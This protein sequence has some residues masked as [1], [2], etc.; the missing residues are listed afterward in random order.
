MLLGIKR[1]VVTAVL[2]VPAG[3]IAGVT[4]N[5]GGG[6]SDLSWLAPFGAAAPFAA[7]ALLQM[8]RAQAKLDKMETEHKAD[9]QEAEKEHRAEAE[10][11]REE[12]RQLRIESQQRERELVLRFGNII[13]DSALLYKE[14]NTAVA[15]I[16]QSVATQQ[17]SS[18][19]NAARSEEPALHR[20]LE[21]I[22]ELTQTM[23][24]ETHD[25]PAERS[26]S[27]DHGS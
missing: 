10:R 22:Q 21:A 27:D 17:V 2:G 4:E 13:Y 1:H 9:L 20:V 14:G 7:L 16:A 26:G 19:T 24:G 3:V 23:S 6:G 18:A 25:N 11:L 8:N 5:T 12:A 15:S